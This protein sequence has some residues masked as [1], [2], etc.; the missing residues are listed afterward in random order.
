M[1]QHKEQEWKEFKKQKKHIVKNN[2]KVCSII[3]NTNQEVNDDKETA[4][5]KQW[6]SL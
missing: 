6:L 2:I 5:L 3:T 1:I 4:E